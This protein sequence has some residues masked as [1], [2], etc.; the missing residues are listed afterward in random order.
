MYVLQYFFD[1][2]I[3][4]GLKGHSPHK[5]QSVCTLWELA[6]AVTNR[7]KCKSVYQLYTAFCF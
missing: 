5:Q 1:N 2:N 7:K 3:N 6:K 4:R